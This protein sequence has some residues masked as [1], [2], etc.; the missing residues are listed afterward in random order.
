MTVHVGDPS[1]LSTCTL[2]KT[3]L[4]LANIKLYKKSK[5]AI[6]KFHTVIQGLV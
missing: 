3:T 5:G 4:I 1:K 2:G 6:Q